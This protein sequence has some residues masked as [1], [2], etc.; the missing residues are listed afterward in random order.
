MGVSRELLPKWEDLQ[1]VVAQLH[2]LPLLDEEDVA[3]RIVI[4]PGAKKPLHLDIPIFVSDMSF[5]ALSEEAKIALAKGAEAAGTGICSGE[6]GMLPEEQAANSRY[7]YELASA[8]FGFS[9]DKVQKTQAF[10]FK[11]GQGAKTGTGGHLP[12]HKVVGQIVAQLEKSGV[13]DNTLLIFT[14]DN[15][16]YKGSRGFAGKWSHY[17]ESL[18]VPLVIY[19]PRQPSS[20]GGVQRAEIALNIDVAPSLLSAAGLPTV[21]LLA[22]STQPG[23]P[24]TG[25]STSSVE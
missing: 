13:R 23:Y 19:D 11:G 7:F 16:Y 5:G 4:G 25:V 3:T 8:R 17:E 14:G 18:R 24:A 10:H 9:W 2:K 12:G 6:G 21:V 22:V 15:G 1:F 20:R